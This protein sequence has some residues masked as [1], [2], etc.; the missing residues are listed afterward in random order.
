MTNY[1][2]Y[3]TDCRKEISELRRM[4]K[5]NGFAIAD[6]WETNR[7]R[8]ARFKRYFYKTTKKTWTERKVW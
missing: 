6:M 4:G 7:L 8:T 2:H 1:P 3:H 5:R